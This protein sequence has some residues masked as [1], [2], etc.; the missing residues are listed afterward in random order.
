MAKSKTEKPEHE[1]L[2]KIHA[3]IEYEKFLLGHI[4]DGKVEHAEAFDALKPEMFFL[5]QHQQ[6][7]SA[8]IELREKKI[9][10]DVISLCEALTAS[11]EIEDCGGI[12]YLS[13]LGADLPHVKHLDNFTTGI[14]RAWRLRRYQSFAITLG[15]LLEQ[16]QMTEEKFLQAASE[17]VSRLLSDYDFAA[18]MGHTFYDAGVE[19]L[20]SLD[21]KKIIR[22]TTGIATI[23]DLT[24]GIHSGELAVITASTGT[25]KTL[26]AQQIRRRCCERDWHT[27]YCSG[28]MLARHLVARDVASE[29][30]VAHM[31]MR[32]PERITESERFALMEAVSHLCRNCRVLDGDLTLQRIRTAARA[33]HRKQG[34]ELLVVDYDELVEAPGKT[35]WEQERNITRAMKSMAMELR[36]PAILISQLRKAPSGEAAFNPKINDI[37]GSSSKGKHS[38]VVIY[39][40]REYVRDLK[41]DETDAKMFVLKSRDGRIGQAECTF[42]VHTLRFEDKSEDFHPKPD[43]FPR[44]SRRDI[45]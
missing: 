41:G 6:I 7:F 10:I 33:M 8:M 21:E 11:G 37:Y 42:N 15:Q 27:L 2:P 18:D 40:D 20:I 13:T 3:N 43:L 25:G 14:G 45:D 16:T 39:V 4:L 17:G 5:K 38:S 36:C 29:A 24:G 28:E 31:K 1:N 32:L 35:E 9:E 23:D 22:A 12:P 26:L 34:L 30:R 44:A 19:L